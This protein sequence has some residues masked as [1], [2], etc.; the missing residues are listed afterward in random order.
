MHCNSLLSG[1]RARLAIL[2]VLAFTLS[3][4]CARPLGPPGGIP[5]REPP[6][7]IGVSP[8]QRAIVPGFSGK[9][10]FT[11]DET[12]S[13]RGAVPDLVEVSPETGRIFFERDGRE[14]KVEIEG[15]WQPNQIYR[16]VVLPGLQD[17]FN[18]ARKE[19]AE[20]VFSTGPVIPNTAIAGLIRDRVTGQPVASAR[21]TAISRVDSVTHVT[22]TDA[23][24]FFALRYMPLGNFLIRAYED[25]NRNHRPDFPEKQ[26]DGNAALGFAADTQVVELS[27]MQPDTTPARVLRAEFKDSLQ[28]RVF[29]DDYLEPGRQQQLTASLFQLPDSTAVPVAQVLSQREYESIRAAEQ[30]RQDSITQAQRDTARG[31][32]L[33][34]QR[35]RPAPPAQVPVSRP[36][37]VPPDTSVVLPF[38]EIVVV[39]AQPLRPR[40]RYRVIVQGA[41]NIAEIAGGGGTTTFETP[42][43]ARADTTGTRPDTTGVRPDTSRT[44]SP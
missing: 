5:D 42:A 7:L 2:G 29:F 4:S 17:R 28:I 22:A 16:V 44:R 39:P 34:A 12:L 32:T 36:G 43:P 10:V 27:L 18:N 8:A 24:G 6:Q 31:D 37:V 21:V 41:F 1:A 40:T 35:P 30:A 19:T 26:A 13:E 14:I 15:G 23:D 3:I 9:V 38:Q 33:A 20:I 25:R 11:F